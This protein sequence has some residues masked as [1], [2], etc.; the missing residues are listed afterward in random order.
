[1]HHNNL[2][3]IF[4]FSLESCLCITIINLNLHFHIIHSST[5]KSLQHY[6]NILMYHN[7][8]FCSFAFLLLVAPCIVVAPCLVV[9]PFNPCYS[10]CCSFSCCSFSINDNIPNRSSY[11]QID[12][13][14]W[15]KGPRKEGVTNLYHE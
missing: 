13:G 10:L 5:N 9:A 4:A 11:H 3:N 12:G 14:S 6:Q 8:S 15:R 2:C 7:S 1:M